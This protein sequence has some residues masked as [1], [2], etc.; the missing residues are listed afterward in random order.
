MATRDGYQALGRV[1]ALLWVGPVLILAAT[2]APRLTA[3]SPMWRGLLTGFSAMVALL[4]TVVVVFFLA[5]RFGH[6]LTSDQPRL[7][8][9]ACKT[10]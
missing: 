1:F 10:A 8:P 9:R 7:P 4:W 6:L 3:L 2:L 5:F